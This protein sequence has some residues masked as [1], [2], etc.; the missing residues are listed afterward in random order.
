M[1]DVGGCEHTATYRSGKRTPDTTRIQKLFCFKFVHTAGF[2]ISF[3]FT[4][5]VRF[6]THGQ[7]SGFLVGC[8]S[9]YTMLFAC[10]ADLP[11][12]NSTFTLELE[13][14]RTSF[15][16]RKLFHKDS[17]R[18]IVWSIYFLKHIYTLGYG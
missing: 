18:H 9:T 17:L 10:P 8:L 15:K 5:P 12:K 4:R 7:G 11:S 13:R 1:G 14:T 3:E 2:M 16:F 6:M